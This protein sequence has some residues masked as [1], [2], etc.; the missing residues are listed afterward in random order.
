MPPAC[1]CQIVC[2]TNAGARSDCGNLLR[3]VT[4]SSVV[5][6]TCMVE[7]VDNVVVCSS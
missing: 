2:G 3:L 1:P 6:S 5:E 7:C 4:M